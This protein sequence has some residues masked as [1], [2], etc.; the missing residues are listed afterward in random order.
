LG[1]ATESEFN[2]EQWRKRHIDSWPRDNAKAK[3]IPN[4]IATYNFNNYKAPKLYHKLDNECKVDV[5]PYFTVHNPM[6]L[7]GMTWKCA[8]SLFYKISTGS[9]LVKAVQAG[10]YPSAP[11]RVYRY[12]PILPEELKESMDKFGMNT[13]RPLAK[14]RVEVF[15]MFLRVKRF[16]MPGLHLRY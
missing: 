12:T 1:E 4:A 7:A 5:V 9:D 15:K 13:M 16:G 8:C 6:F 3:L 11:T 2:P 14:W 10:K